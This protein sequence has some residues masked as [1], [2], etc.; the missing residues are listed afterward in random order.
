MR[1]Q[2]IGEP[3][4]N[5][6][7]DAR[8]TGV[9]RGGGSSIAFIDFNGFVVGVTAPGIP[10]M[11]NGLE[12]EKDGAEPLPLPTGSW[13]VPGTP[14]V[15]MPGAMTAGGQ[16]ITWSVQLTR[17]WRSALRVDA[18]A[19]T[20][21]R[22]GAAILTGCGVQ[23]TV[24]PAAL[25]AECVV[26]EDYSERDALALLLA[27]LKTRDPE[28]AG[29]AAG[30]LIGRGPGLTPVGDDL[31]TA[32]AGVVVGVAHAA[33]W[34]DDERNRWLAAIRALPLRV[35]TTALSATLIELALHGHVIE[36]MHR[37]LAVAP[38]DAERWRHALGALERIGSST[39]KAYSVATGA[40]ALMCTA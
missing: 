21:H 19:P 6:I 30:Q 5:L 9:V 33:G 15:I 13:L 34:S 12:L 2:T 7:G 22:R 36:P 17:V 20:L 35:A 10:L 31:V 27:S 4:V 14:A 40:A 26:L 23:P 29:A 39:G 37:L 38:N 28:L 25:A 16:T 1:A 8:R 11:P 24:D 3:V 18:D 32:A